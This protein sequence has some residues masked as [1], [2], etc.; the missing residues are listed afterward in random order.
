MYPHMRLL[1]FCVILFL[2]PAGCLLVTDRFVSRI[3][4]DFLQDSTWQ[5]NRYDRIVEM[6]PPRAATLRNGAQIRLLKHLTDGHSVTAAVCTSGAGSY[7]RLFDRLT[8]RCNE[9]SVLRRARFAALIGVG[10]ALIAFALV[11]VSRI[12]VRRYEHQ[13]DWAGPWTAWFILR[14]IHVVL[15]VQVA[16]ALAGFAILLQTLLSR[17]VYAYAALVIPWIGL[18]WVERT[19]AAGFIQAQKVVAFR[20]RRRARAMRARA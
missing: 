10:V 4:S 9:W 2:A 19:T 13:Q 7:S 17:S 5:I 15:A 16:A 11:L 8:I 14:G 18:F 1:A 6:Y 12:G 20:P 3:E